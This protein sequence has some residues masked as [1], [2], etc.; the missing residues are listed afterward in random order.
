MPRDQTNSADPRVPVGAVGYADSDHIHEDIVS[1]LLSLNTRFGSP[2][3]SID[4][5]NALIECHH[6]GEDAPPLSQARRR[7]NRGPRMA[8][9]AQSHGQDGQDQMEAERQWRLPQLGLS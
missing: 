8:Q 3:S 2:P 6:G 1:S 7:R 9:E 4:N 5:T